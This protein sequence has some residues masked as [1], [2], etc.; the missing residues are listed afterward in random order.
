MVRRR[1]AEPRAA[2]GLEWLEADGL[3]GFACGTVAGREDPPVSRLVR[4]GDPSAAP[5]LDAGFRLRGVPDRPTARD[6]PLDAGV[7]EGRLPRRG[8]HLA[9]FALEPFPTWTLPG[10]RVGDRALA[11]PRPRPL[12]HDRALRQPR[13]RR[14]RPARPPAAALPGS[15]RAPARTDGTGRHDRG[16]RRGVLGAAGALPAAALPA[17][18]RSP[19]RAPSRPGTATSSTPRRKSA[20]TTP[21]RTSGARSNGT[22]SL[23]PG[24]EAFLLFS[25]E[26]VAADP[27]HLME[28]ERRR[29]EAFARTGDPMLRRDGAA[30]GSLPRRGR[31]PR[32]HDPGRFPVVHGL[33]ARQHDRGA[34]A[35]AWRRAAS[36]PSPASSTP[37]RPLRRDGL[38]P[39]NFAGDDGEPE[40]NSVD[41]PLWLILAVE[42]FA[43]ARRDASRPAPLL[44]AVRS[45]LESYRAGTRLGI[46]VA[47]DGLVSA[48]SPGRAADLD[49]RHRRRPARHARA[50]E[51]RWRS[52][53]SGTPRLKSAARAGA[54]CRR[55]RPGPG[56]RV[57]SLARRA[58]IQRDLL[59]WRQGHLYDVVG[60]DGPDASRAPEP[61]LRRLAHRRPSPAAP[62]PGGLLD[63]AAAAADALRPAHARPQGPAL[64]G[65]V[66]GRRRPSATGPTTRAPCGPGCSAPS[67]TRTSACSA[68]PRSPAARCAPWLAP[69]RAHLREA[70]LG[71]ISE[72]FDGDPPHTPRGCFAQAWSVAEIARII[73]THLQAREGE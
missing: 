57:R 52:T 1:V 19:R 47:G 15:R 37:T 40:F 62:R 20:A 17:R 26:E 48:W 59:E 42:W 16:P 22:W 67:P 25:L 7:R 54:A 50:R 56:A 69:L 46:A 39:N 18:R 24:G 28:A 13:F 53:R 71:S 64:L 68:A 27:A 11:L 4:P 31:L 44:A 30:G 34:R 9:R 33:G 65:A 5:A 51:G 12:H 10:R 35:R 36:A 2:L 49:G 32:R 14:G 70:G 66:P 6:R 63:G 55:D 72:I 58:A 21:T 23:P 60:P 38:L 73:Y 61:D 3:G 29:R 45:I 8:R 41:A 43:R